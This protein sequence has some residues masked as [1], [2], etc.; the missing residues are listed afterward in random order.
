MGFYV[1]MIKG[2][3]MSSIAQ[4]SSITLELEV[5]L[6]VWKSND[7]VPGFMKQNDNLNMLRSLEDQ[8]IKDDLKWSLR[9]LQLM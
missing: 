5:F 3:G 2:K 9:S 1:A 4:N 7:R 6:P 8:D